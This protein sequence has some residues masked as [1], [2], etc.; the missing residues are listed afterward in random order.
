MSE[1][2]GYGSDMLDV[3]RPDLVDLPGVCAVGD[4]VDLVDGF[5]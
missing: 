4:E 2:S 3:G 5:Q 1:P